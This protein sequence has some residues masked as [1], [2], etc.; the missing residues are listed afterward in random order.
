MLERMPECGSGGVIGRTLPLG[1]QRPTSSG[2]SVHGVHISTG[3]YELLALLLALGY[4]VVLSQTPTEQFK[5]FSNYLVYAEHSWHRLLSLFDRGVLETLANEPVWL[6]I[7][8][9]L[10]AFLQPEVVVRTIVFTSGAL[11]AW[12]FLRSRPQ[13]FVWLLLFLVFPVVLKNHFVHLR[14]GAAIALFLVGWFSPNR[15]ARWLLMGLSPFVHASFFFVLLV[16]SVARSALRIRL[17][18][19]LRTL[20]FVVMG[21]SVGVGLGWLAAAVGAR[22]AQEYD[23]TMTDVSGLGFVFWL[24]VLVLMA[25]EGRIFLRNY[26]FETGMIAFYLATYWLV[27]VTARIFESGLLLVLLAGL[28]LTGWRR[29]GFLSIILVYGTLMWGLRLGQPALGFGIG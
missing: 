17:G 23:F 6:L 21:V 25:M 16:L 28:A 19:D 27:E 29:V 10:G 14:Q 13:D 9:A 5:D 7:N 8:A 18:P 12:V 1:G 24:G 3:F 4:G 20:I 11:V 2:R 15:F 26:V 22:Q